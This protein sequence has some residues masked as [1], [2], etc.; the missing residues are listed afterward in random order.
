VSVLIR[1]LPNDN[2]FTRNYSVELM[3]SL[4][5]TV[6]IEPRASLSAADQTAQEDPRL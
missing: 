1:W 2:G 3:A 5:Q 6:G 4:N